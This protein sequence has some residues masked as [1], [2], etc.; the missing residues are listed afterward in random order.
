MSIVLEA[1][2]SHAGDRPN[3][4]ALA[5]GQSSFTYATLLSEID[6]VA[7][8]LGKRLAAGSGSVAIALPN[9][10]AWVVL[11]LALIKLCRAA[12][13]LPSFFTPAQITHAIEDGDA[14]WIIAAHAPGAPIAIAGATVYLRELDGGGR[15]PTKIAKVTYTSGSTGAP[16]GVCLSQAQLEAVAQSIVDRV[17][18]DFAGVHM[19]VLPLSILLENV[20]GLYPILI[21]GG[22][23]RVEP[24]KALGFADPFKP[25]FGQLGRALI[26]GNATSLILVPELL[27]G[28][29]AAKW[30]GR[31]NLPKLRFV[32]VGGAK[33]AP[34][35][36]A[37]AHEH[38]LPVY[39][40]YGLSECASVVAVNTPSAHRAGSVGKPLPHLGVSIAEDGEI[41]VTANGTHGSVHTGDLGRLDG[42]GFLY[43]TG[44]KSN[45]IITSFGRNVSP[46]W[47]ESELLVEPQVRQA[48][49]FGEASPTLGA[50][51]APTFPNL[52]RDD[53][54]YAV[55]RANARLPA[56]AQIA[57]FHIIEPLSAERG[58]LT[59]NGRAMRAAVLDAYRDIVHRV[60]V[61]A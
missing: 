24:P 25:D 18:A 46:E 48:I 36:I 39:E 23:Y 29:L 7:E 9:G 2:A 47:V 27:R 30:L 16:K 22:C 61:L 20:A 33:V 38:G 8:V 58:L 19:P 45:L 42:D 26:A 21:A 34:E 56:Y 13:P 50:L 12:L 43:V 55:A 35:L 31:M 54:G 28:I 5:S 41:V 3:T 32:A 53:I 17:G 10:P 14:G 57:H 52:N 4:I 51:I 40:G 6:V 60:E 49:V 15:L 44:R 11:D 37:S 59:G 1:I